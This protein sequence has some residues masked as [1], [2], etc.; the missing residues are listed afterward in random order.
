MDIASQKIRIYLQIQIHSSYKPKLSKISRQINSQGGKYVYNKIDEYCKKVNK[1]INTIKILIIGIAF[2]G[3]PETSD[4]RYSS[5]I[6]LINLFSNK[7]NLYLHDSVVSK[8]DL[9]KVGA[10]VVEELEEG[11]HNKDAVIFMNNHPMHT[12]IQLSKLLNS[13]NNSPLFFDGWNQFVSTEVERVNNT[14][15]STMGYL[16]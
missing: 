2:K 10:N 7:E 15:Y 1:D 13:M 3:F 9:L 8:E 6:D 5:S 16:S 14:K 11:F 4:I 12:K